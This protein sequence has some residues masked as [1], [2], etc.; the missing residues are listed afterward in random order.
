MDNQT[1][2]SATHTTPTTPVQA[3]G[4][5]DKPE[6]E[7]PAPA[8]GD[9]VNV[10]ELVP[11]AEVIG[12]GIRIRP[13]QPYEL[14][15]VLF[16]E[17]K[18]VLLDRE[19]QHYRYYSRANQQTYNV[20]NVCEING[21][22]PLPANQSA[23]ETL[24]EESWDRFSNQ[25][26][27]N[28]QAAV[29]APIVTID[30]SALHA[31][32]LKSEEN[33]YYAMRNAFVPFF[34]IYL[35]S[36]PS[37]V[38]DLDLE[39]ASFDTF[40]TKK[41][42]EY[43]RIFDRFGTH[44][45]KC[46]WVGGKASLVFI[47]S[48][49]SKLTEQEIKIGIQAS[50][51]GLV[52]GNVSSDKKD[53]IEALKNNSS[54]RVF[55]SGGDK[56]LLAQLSKLDEKGYNEWLESIKLSPEVIQ[57]EVAGIWTLL[58]N[59]VAAEV[60]KRAYIEE[61][62][63]VPLKAIVP[64]G[65]SSYFLNRRGHIFAYNPRPASGEPKAE[66]I[67]FDP[68]AFQK[69]PINPV[70]LQKALDENPALRGM[71]LSDFESSQ[72]ASSTAGTVVGPVIA[73]LGQLSDR[74][75]KLVKYLTVLFTDPRY[76]PFTYPDSAFSLYGFGNGLDGMIDLFEKGKCLRMQID[77]DTSEV[78]AG[79]PMAINKVWLGVDFDRVDATVAVASSNRIYFF[80]GSEYIRV[81]YDG[82]QVIGKTKRNPIEGHWPGV[83]F[84]RLDAAFYYG[85]SKAYFFSGD[86]YI[87]YDLA[88][89]R[90]D[91]GYPRYLSSNYVEDWELFE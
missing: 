45:V 90:A 10:Q 51:G 19:H 50:I 91:P 36:V 73:K 85:N 55:G 48:K 20:P 58:E 61:S 4:T 44:Y 31:A 89:G 81:E 63:F 42:D 71:K 68:V 69:A 13:R 1:A 38:K 75:L 70:A 7:T 9:E 86:Q 64:I 74:K 2:E 3:S 29:N 79:Y 22:P 27:F 30:P 6:S 66:D 56:I 47:V 77:G 18:D 80:R 40:N 34:S 65:A 24:I 14:K 35:P 88:L 23:G 62:S 54:C 72:I 15:D 5:S 60:L 52:S 87:R 78:A 28:V 43:N 49:S 32:N 11:G 26:T 33:S 84:E 39:V 37:S 16:D 25:L 17:F 57:L 46:A 67:P 41:R 83:V 59:Q 21:S 76:S 12:R 82:R 53:T 8:S